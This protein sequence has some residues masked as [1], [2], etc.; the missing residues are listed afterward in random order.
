MSM[1]LVK[2]HVLEGRY[3]TARLDKVSGA[4]QAALINTLGVPPED[5]YQLI[6]EFP[7]DRFRHTKSFVGL[8]YTDDL[9]ILDVTF[10]EGRPP[11]KR[12]ALLKDINAR[13]S[14]EAELAPDDVMITIY[15]A[16]GVNFSF[17][18]GEAQRANAVSS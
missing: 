9:I 17:G 1:P 11:E 12:L 7:R 2:I 4:I 18:R 5:F 8:H 3:D 16:P 15:E 13:V 14:K 6:F 10:I